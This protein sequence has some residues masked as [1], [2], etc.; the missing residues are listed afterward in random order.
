MSENIDAAAQLVVTTKR[1]V[2]RLFNVR[3]ETVIAWEKTRGMPVR[4]DGHYDLYDIMRWYEERQ[5]VKKGGSHNTLAKEKL[6]L[7]IATKRLKLQKEAGE[8]VSRA[9][10][11]SKIE[12]MFALVRTRL[13]AIPDELAATVPA[14]LRAQF[15]ADCGHK[16]QLILRAMANWGGIDDE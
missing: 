3:L 9:A 8:L 4:S 12:T 14:K 1:A 16:I 13:Q 10:A 5:S 6:Q 2:A 7:E 11:E 15:V